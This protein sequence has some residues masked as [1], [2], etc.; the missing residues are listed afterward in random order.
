MFGIRSL[1]RWLG[2]RLTLT[3]S[4]W[5]RFLGGL[6]STR[7]G[8]AHR[9]AAARDEGED[10]QAPGRKANA[11]P[12]L[13]HD[14]LLVASGEVDSHGRLCFVHRRCHGVPDVFGRLL[15]GDRLT[16]LFPAAADAIRVALTGGSARFEVELSE[17]DETE[18]LLPSW[19]GEG[20]AGP[21]G[22]GGAVWFVRD[23][24]IRRQ[25]QEQILAA[26]DNAREELAAEIHDELGQHLTGLICHA[27]ALQNSVVVTYPEFA[28][29][30]AQL[31]GGAKEALNV[32]R[33]IAHGHSTRAYEGLAPEP[34]LREM[35][36]QIMRLQPV[37]VRIEAGPDPFPL[38][39]ED[40]RHLTRMVQEAVTNAVRHGHAQTVVLRLDN[41]RRELV[42]SDDGAGFDPARVK[43]GT[44]LGFTLM[45]HRAR[46]MRGE[47]SVTSTPGQG[48][49]VTCRWRSA[50]SVKNDPA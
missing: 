48:T 38:S 24:S 43:P 27:T 49:R 17:D 36:K 21:S 4:P 23:L 14:N 31:V 35:A 33:E 25:L 26:Q 29:E 42:I 44:S 46:L 13:L 20:F 3:E 18:A 40:T 6:P 34:A 2:V 22:D 32:A 30:V 11:L 19:I 8:V 41:A 5:R 37:A 1:R 50:A 28:Q 39:T 7:G 10:A 9:H 47:L 15:V 45:R 12:E 16:D